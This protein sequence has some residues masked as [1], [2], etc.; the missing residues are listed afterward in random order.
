MSNTTTLNL[1]LANYTK[2]VTGTGAN[3]RSLE[4]TFTQAE[5]VSSL[6]PQSPINSYS[7]SAIWIAGRRYTT[8]ADWTKAWAQAY[9]TN[10]Q[11]GIKVKTAGTRPTTVSAKNITLGSGASL[12]ASTPS[13]SVVDSR[14]TAV[15]TVQDGERVVLVTGPQGLTGPP[16][17]P[18][19]L[20]ADGRNGVGV[21]N[22][23]VDAGGNLLVELDNGNIVNAG[24]VNL[25][26]SIGSITQ[27]NPVSASITG[28]GLSTELNIVLPNTAALGLGNVTNESKVTMFNNPTFTGTAA[29]TGTV[30][31]V[32]AAMVGLGNVNNE[33]KLT[34]FASPAFTGVPTAPTA[35]AGTN[36]T[37][38]ATTQYVRTEVANLVNSAP[39]A[40]DT[41]DELAAALG[42]DASFASTVTASIGLKAPLDSP[43]FT[44]TVTGITKTMVGLG[45]V[46]NETKATAFT[47]PT[48]TGTVTAPTVLLAPA[49]FSITQESTK[50]VFK[51]NG[52]TIASMDS[53][54]NIISAANVTAYGT[55]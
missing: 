41:L 45:N 12:S 20:G 35:T 5:I 6:P 32:S 49:G 33:S 18:G 15:R 30:T 19:T 37:Q 21:Q 50:L 39:G 34:M 25:S 27:G 29:F 1:D 38:I 31:G 47:S 7:I 11:A 4:L 13:V 3:P 14:S 55:P 26:L 52:N 43:A 23:A 44:G 9:V 17:V 46:L 28:A 36:T 40:L 24:A 2:I 54:G 22:I 10:R 16:G 51:Y 42:D 8:V 53:T 48:F